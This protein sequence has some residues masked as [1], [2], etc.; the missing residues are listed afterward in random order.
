M[1]YQS[2]LNAK[3]TG[4]KNLGRK[5]CTSNRNDRKLENTVKQSQFKHLRE[6]HKEWRGTESMLLEVQCEVSTVSDDLG[7]HVICWCWST[8]FSEVNA[9]I[10]QEILE[11]FMLPSADKLYRDADFIFQQNL[12]PAHTA[13]GTKSWFNDQFNA[14]VQCCAWLASK[15]A[16]PEPHRESMGYCQEEDQRPDPTMQMSWR[17]LSKKPGFPYH[18]SSATNW[19]PP[20]HAELRQ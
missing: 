5:R 10:Y 17:P 2:I 8:V 20:C 7:C 12:A 3:L 9:A 15:L 19:S 1:L 11:H 6:L 16:W 4:R 18:L 13:K 14:V